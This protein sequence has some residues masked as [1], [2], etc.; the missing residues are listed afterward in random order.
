MGENLW[1]IRINVRRFTLNTSLKCMEQCV[2]AIEDLHCVGFLHRD[3]KPG[4]FCAGIKGTKN[5]HIIYLLDFGLCR[6]FV[7]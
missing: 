7:G 1:D 4:N 5:A 2:M 6:K 3:I